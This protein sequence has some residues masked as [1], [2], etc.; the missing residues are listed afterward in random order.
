MYCLCSGYAHF[1]LGE[2]SGLIIKRNIKRIMKF[3]IN[4]WV[5]LILFSIIGIVLKSEDIPISFER[6]LVMYF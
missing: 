6:F 5:I 2:T 4:Y 1:R 3:L